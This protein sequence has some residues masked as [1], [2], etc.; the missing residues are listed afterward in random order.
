[1]VQFGRQLPRL[2]AGILANHRVGR[3]ALCLPDLL[4]L[5]AWRFN[6]TESQDSLLAA[7]GERE[8]RG[9][10][11]RW[12]ARLPGLPATPELGYT[13]TQRTR[14]SG[15]QF[16]LG[17]QG[18]DQPDRLPGP[19]QDRQLLH[20]WTVCPVYRAALRADRAA[21]RPG[22]LPATARLV[23]AVNTRL[24]FSPPAVTLRGLQ[25]AWDACR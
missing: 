9:L 5:A 13:N 22:L 4:H 3:G 24:G 11:R 16:R 14:E 8:M 12:R 23:A 20:F 17:W 21:G 10:G 7:A 6:L 25:L 15:R 19:L 1:M 18:G 2:Q